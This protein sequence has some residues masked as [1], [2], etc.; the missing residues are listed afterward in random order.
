MHTVELSLQP[1]QLSAVMANMRMWLDERRFEPA[2]FICRDT[3]GGIVVSVDFSVTAEARAFA[4]RF[5]G[6]VATLRPGGDNNRRPGAS[7]N[8][9]AES[10]VG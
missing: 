8:L 5:S 6:V 2:A 3:G 4:D 1:E 9:P 7:R 10:A